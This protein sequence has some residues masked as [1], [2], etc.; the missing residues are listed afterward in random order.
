M[1]ITINHL[2]TQLSQPPRR[3]ASGATR[4]A[5]HLPRHRSLPSVP[6]FAAAQVGRREARTTARKA[7]AGP[8][9]AALGGISS[10]FERRRWYHRPA[11]A[12]LRGSPGPG[13]S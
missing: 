2:K 9:P 3:S 8:F 12:E 13:P 10:S 7:A 6:C 11:A 4:V 5:V 1:D